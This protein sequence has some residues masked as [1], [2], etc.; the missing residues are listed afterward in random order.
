MARTPEADP[1]LEARTILR[2]L[3]DVPWSWQEVPAPTGI[4]AFRG[5]APGW[6]ASVG[7]YGEARSAVY[8]AIVSRGPAIF[9]LP[10]DHALALWK[11]AT[12]GIR[13]P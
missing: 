11:Q 12:A 5:S 3:P 8:F 13:T 4:R 1:T 6:S 9:K 7:C 2:A 10:R